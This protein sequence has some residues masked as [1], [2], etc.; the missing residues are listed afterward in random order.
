MEYENCKQPSRV[1][2]AIVGV[3][4]VFII[5]YMLFFPREHLQ[6]VDAG[7]NILYGVPVNMH[8]RQPNRYN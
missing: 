6:V 4:I 8:P 1:L 3:L 2:P 5:V 7:R